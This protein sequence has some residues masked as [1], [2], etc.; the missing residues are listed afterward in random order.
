MLILKIEVGVDALISARRVRDHVGVIKQIWL[1]PQS[2]HQFC[3]LVVSG[4]PKVDREF[5]WS[6]SHKTVVNILDLFLLRLIRN[7]SLLM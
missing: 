1:V 4:D 7:I 6:S 5:V 3:A 2:G